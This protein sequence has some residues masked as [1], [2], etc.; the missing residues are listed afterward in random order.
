MIAGQK[1]LKSYFIVTFI[2]V[3]KSCHLCLFDQ[4][5]LEGLERLEELRRFKP[6]RFLELH[7][8]VLGSRLAFVTELPQHGDL[9]TYICSEPQSPQDKVELMRQVV[10][11]L[12]AMVS[13]NN[14]KEK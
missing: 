7:K 10:V 11:A 9:L 13:R 5:F 2:T 14:G 3:I 4:A 8:Y 1:L 6:Q 12:L